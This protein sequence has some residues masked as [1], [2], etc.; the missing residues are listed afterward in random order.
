MSPTF[1]GDEKG[2]RRMN[3]RTDRL[4]WASSVILSFAIRD[5]PVASPNRRADWKVASR[6]VTMGR[7]LLLGT[8]P[9][10]ACMGNPGLETR[11]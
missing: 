7:P 8:H 1:S 3:I 2:R 11:P 9:S 10:R 5:V 6:S 4:N